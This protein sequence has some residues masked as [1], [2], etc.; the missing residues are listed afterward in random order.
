MTIYLQK[1]QRKISKN[2]NNQAESNR[3]KHNKE[4]TVLVIYIIM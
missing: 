4:I 2:N 3:Y 1:K